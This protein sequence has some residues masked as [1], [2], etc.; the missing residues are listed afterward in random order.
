MYNNKEDRNRRRLRLANGTCCLC[1]LKGEIPWLGREYC[2][3]HWNELQNNLRENE[4][5]VKIQR[6]KKQKEIEKIKEKTIRNFLRNRTN[7]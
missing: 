6:E 5:N 7:R 3:F 4:A 1:D 2:Y